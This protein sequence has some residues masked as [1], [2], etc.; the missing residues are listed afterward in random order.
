MNK[1]KSPKAIAF[2]LYSVKEEITNSIIHGLGALCAIAGLVI[3]NLK[4]TGFF[5]GDREARLSIIAVLIFAVTMIGMF[6]IS[7]LYHA[8]QHKGAKDILRR[9]D[10]CMIFIFI[11]GT[12]TPFCLIGLQGAW[13]WS[14]LS[15]EWAMAIIGITL[16]ILDCKAL[17]KIEI[18]AYVLMGWAIVVGIIPLIRS[19]PIESVVLLVLGGITYTMGIFWYKKKDLKY[20]HAIWHTFVIMGAVL[21]WFAVWNLFD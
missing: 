12:Y 19:A 9:M 4:T 18:A 21:H 2:P 14:I 10:H 16:N 11:A 8:I 3:L 15:F 13:G 5:S 7:T 6:L 1:L 17:K 20:T